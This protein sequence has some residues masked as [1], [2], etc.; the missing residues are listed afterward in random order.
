MSNITVTHAASGLVQLEVL[1]TERITPHM[2]RVTFGGADL[3]R[4]T[5]RGFDA[6]AG[7]LRDMPR[8]AAG[9]ALIELQDA[10]DRQPLDAPEGMTVYWLEREPAAAPGSVALP[11]FAALDL[12]A[13]D[14]QAFAVGEARVATGSRRHL[15]R[16]RG[17]AK[18]R[19]T[20][21]GYWRQGRASG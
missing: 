8:D 18:E 5:Y 13:E 12:D 19:V 20:F 4:F 9:H 1:R 10:A 21:S 6:V 2:N 14:L 16:D 11:T 15:V 7:I 3:A 17:V